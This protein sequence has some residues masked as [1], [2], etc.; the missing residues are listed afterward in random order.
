MPP[1]DRFSYFFAL[2][3]PVELVP[4][5]APHRD[6]TSAPLFGKIVDDARLHVSVL[7]LGAFAEPQ[8]GLVALANA[9]LGEQ[10]LPAC[11]C[12]L[13]QLVRGKRS[14][15]LVSSR[16]YD[17][18]TLLQTA[19]LDAYHVPEGDRSASLPKPHIT[20]RYDQPEAPT[21]AITPVAWHAE[22]LVLVE[23]RIGHGRHEILGRWPLQQ[24]FEEC[25]DWVSA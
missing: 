20:L 1:L 4:E 2:E 13:D 12:Y 3:P 18:L 24:S 6:S 7:G 16:A 11:C 10:R 22:E 8:P 9:A 23:S 17:D 19:L 25:F 15:L 5:I 21:Q 14:M